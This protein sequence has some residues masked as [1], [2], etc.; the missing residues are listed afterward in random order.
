M[1]TDRGGPVHGTAGTWLQGL[2]GQFPDLA[3]KLLY[4]GQAS[5]GR[6]GLCLPDFSLSTASSSSC[7]DFVPQGRVEDASGG[8][9]QEEP[10][11]SSEAQEGSPSSHLPRTSPDCFSFPDASGGHYLQNRP[12][13]TQSLAVELAPKGMQVIPSLTL[14]IQELPGHPPCAFPS[15][16]TLP[17]THTLRLPML[18]P[19]PADAE[20]SRFSL[21]CT[22]PP[23]CQGRP[24]FCP[25]TIYL[26]LRL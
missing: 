15:Q 7:T 21:L 26:V 17:E 2:S 12:L 1:E 8:W 6:R 5:T 23:T 9:G 14:R 13:L 24:P 25:F 16:A 10:R 18:R 4:L 22:G 11:P 3:Q 19:R 20:T